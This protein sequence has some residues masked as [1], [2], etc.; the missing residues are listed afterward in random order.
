MY[1]K[2]RQRHSGAFMITLVVVVMLAG[3][4]VNM[5]QMSEKVRGYHEREALLQEQI[6]EQEFRAEEIA[7]YAKYVQTDKFVEEVAKEKLGLVFED[8]I[9]FKKAK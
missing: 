5:H 3:V 2:E 9:V 7:E 1:H 8:E 6:A 4:L